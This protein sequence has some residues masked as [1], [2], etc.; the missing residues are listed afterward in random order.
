MRRGR[1]RGN[2]ENLRMREAFNCCEPMS[3]NSPEVNQI[4]KLLEDRQVEEWAADYDKTHQRVVCEIEKNRARFDDQIVSAPLGLDIEDVT[5]VTEKCLQLRDSYISMEPKIHLGM[6]QVNLPMIDQKHPTLKYIEGFVRDT[7]NQITKMLRNTCK[8]LLEEYKAQYESAR[9]EPSTIQEVVQFALD[10]TDSQEKI[11]PM[12][13]IKVDQVEIQ[14][15]YLTDYGFFS[16]TLTDNDFALG[17]LVIK[18]RANAQGEMEANLDQL[19]SRKAE[20]ERILQEKIDNYGE[21]LKEHFESCKDFINKEVPEVNTENLQER[22]CKSSELWETLQT[23]SRELEDLNRDESLLDLDATKFPLLRS[24]I[25]MFE[26]HHLLWLNSK[27]FYHRYDVWFYGALSE[28]SS[29]KVQDE[30]GTFKNNLSKVRNAL[31]E[32]PD[33]QQIAKDILQSINNLKDPLRL[34]DV[35][36]NRAMRPRHW[37]KMADE[38]GTEIDLASI[39]CLQDAI[40]YGLREHLKI[41]E[42]VSIVATNEFED[43]Q[44]LDAMK[45]EWDG[46]RFELNYYKDTG[47]KILSSVDKIQEALEEHCSKSQ[48]LLNSIFV[49]P[50]FDE[51]EEWTKRLLKIS[52]IFDV[53]I[54]VQQGWMYLQPIFG[55]PDIQQQMPQEGQQFS[56]VN[57]IF[58]KIMQYTVA[59]DLVLEA[60]EK[61]NLLD[62]LQECLSLLSTIKQR[63]NDYLEKKRAAFPRFFFLSNDELLEILAE[64]KDPLRVQPHLKKFFEGINRLQFDENKEIMGMESAEKEKVSFDAIIKPSE[65]KGLVEKWLC[66]TESEMFSSIKRE[67][68][69][70]IDDYEVTPRREWVQKWI[71]QAVLCGATVAWTREVEAAINEDQSGNCT[72]LKE[73]HDQC[74]NQITELVEL[75]RT[76]LPVGLRITLEALI[77]IDVHAKDVVKLLIDE[78]VCSVDSFVWLSQLRYYKGNNDIRVKMVQTDVPYGC[79]YLGNT[80]RL[81]ITPLTD[82]CYRTLMCAMDLHLGGAPEGPAG[83][84]KTETSKDLA[85]ALAKHCV[86]FNCSDQLDHVAMGKFF[87]GI[88]QCGSWA[89]FDEFNRIELEVLSVVAAQIQMIQEAKMKQLAIFDFEG[90]KIKLN[91]S[92][93]A[94]ITMNPG[95]AGRQELPDNLKRLFRPVAMMV[96][97]YALIGEL[98][99]Y[100]RGFKNARPLSVK[101]VQTYKLCS[102]QLSSQ[103]HYDYGMRAVKSVLTAAGNLKLADTSG[104]QSLEDESKLVLRAIIDVNRP[105]FL[106]EDVPLFE[107]ITADL[108]PGIELPPPDRG[109]LI[110][111]LQVELKFRNLQAT[112]WYME[113]LIQLYEM[114]LVR[115]GLM[116]V[117]P[118]F[119]GKTSAF[120]SLADALIRISKKPDKKMDESGVI[121]KIIS[122]KSI[123]S[124]QLYGFVDSVSQ[125]WHDGVLANT[126][127]DY[128]RS[129]EPERKWIILDG[130]VDAVWVENLNTVLDDNKKL[131]LSSGEVVQMSN[132]MNLIFETGDLDQA[133]PATVSRCGMVF[134]DPLQLGVTALIQSFVDGPLTNM[135]PN[136]VQQ[137]QMMHEVLLWIVPPTLAATKGIP[138]FVEMS[139]LYQFNAFERLFVGML[140]QKPDFTIPWMHGLMIFCLIWGAGSTL[141]AEGRKLFDAGFRAVLKDSSKK[142]EGFELADHQM[143]PNKGVLHDWVYTDGG[144]WVPWEEILESG[145]SAAGRALVMTPETTCMQF[146]LKLCLECQFPILFVGPTGTGKSAVTLDHLLSLPPEDC[147]SN[148]VNF[149]ART[150]AALTLDLIMDKLTKHPKRVFGPE[151]GKRCVVFVDDLNMPQKEFYGAQ[152]PIELLRQWLDHGYWFDADTTNMYIKDVRLVSAM[153]VPGNNDVTDRLLRQFIIIGVDKYADATVEKIFSNMVIGHF[154]S[155]VVSLGSSL[156]AASMEVFAQASSNF[157]PLPSTSHY[158][159]N[160]RD[161]SRLIQGC[162]MIPPKKLTNQEKL[163]RLWVHE[164]YRIFYDRLVSI[165]ERETFFGIVKDTVTKCFGKQL[166]SVMLDLLGPSDEPTD[167][168]ISKLYFGDF[169]IPDAYPRDYDEIPDE[170]LLKERLEAYLKEYNETAR[171]PMS[172]V[173]SPYAIGHICRVSRVLQQAN[174]HVLLMGMGGSGRR[175]V[176]RFAANLAGYDIYEIEMTKSFGVTEWRDHLRILLKRAGAECRPTVFLFSDTQ[177]AD[178]SFLEDI[179]LLLNTGDIPNL[180]NSEDKSIILDEVRKIAEKEGR[181]LGQGVLAQ[182]SFFIELVKKNL[183]VVLAMSPI[184]KE[185]RE[186]LRMFPSL[187]NC[188]TLDWLTNWPEDMLQDVANDRLQE[189]D[190]S[191]GL[192]DKEL[193]DKIKQR[194]ID[195]CMSFHTDALELSQIYFN[196][197]KRRVYITSP[198]FLELLNSFKALYATCRD[199]IEA[200]VAGYH[201]G[202]DKLASA[203]KQVAELQEVQKVLEVQLKTKAAEVSALIET[204]EEEKKKTNAIKET[205]Q[206]EEEEA[207]IS[208]AEIAILEA[209]CHT[210]LEKAQPALEE[211]AAALDT[212]KPADITVVKAMKNPPFAVKTVMEAVCIMLKI[213]AERKPGPDGKIVMEFWGPSQKLL[214]DIKFI[215]KLRNYDKDNITDDIMKTIRSKYLKNPNFQVEVVRKSSAACEGLCLWVNALSEYNEVYKVVGPL[216]KQFEEVQADANAKRKLLEEKQETV[217]LLEEKLQVLEQQYQEQADILAKLEADKELCAT[218]LQR[219]EALISGVGGERVRWAE[220]ELYHKGRL[221]TVVGDMLLSVGIIAY[222]GPFSVDYRKNIQKKWVKMCKE[223]NIPCSDSFSMLDSLGDPVEM[224]DWAIAGLPVDD[225]SQ[226]NAVIS[227]NAGRW[228][229]FI[230]P[231]GQ[232]NN[233]IKNAYKEKNLVVLKMSS[234]KYTDQLQKAITDGHPALIEDVGEELDPALNPL[235][236]KQTYILGGMLNIKV[237]NDVVRYSENF[238]LFLTTRLSNPHYLPETAIMVTLLNFAITPQGLEDQLLGLV[239]ATE[240]P[241]LEECRQLLIVESAQNRKELVETERK[242][243]DVLS[244]AEGDILEDET[245][246]N[247]LTNAKKLSETILAK[248]EK[249]KETEIMLEDAR[250]IYLTVARHASELFFCIS[251]LGSLEPMYQYSL[252]WYMNLYVHSIKTAVKPEDP[253]MWLDVIKETFTYNLYRNVCQSLFEKHKLIFS[254]NLCVAMMRLSGVIEES[255]LK[256]LLTTGV[257]ADIADNPDPSWITEKTWA[258]ICRATRMIEQLSGFEESVRSSVALW[259]DWFDSSNPQEETLPAPMD[260]ARRLGWLAVIKCLKPNKLVPAVQKLIAEEIGSQFVDPPTFNLSK[261]FEDSTCSTPLIF[262]LSAGS[263]PTSSLYQLS[264]EMDA[265]KLIFFSMG[266]G[267]GEKAEVAIKQAVKSRSWVIL[268]NCHLATSWMPRLEHI[269]NELLKPDVADKDFRLWLTSYPSSSFPVSILQSGIKMTNEA[270]KG[271]RSNMMRM[272]LNDPLSAEDYLSKRSVAQQKL[273]FGLCLFHAM[274]QERRSF[275]PLGWNIPYEFNDSDFDISVKQMD[276][277]LKGSITIPFDALHYLISECFYG[278]R[279]TDGNDRRLIAS[280]LTNFLSPAVVEEEGYNFSQSGVYSMPEST[281][282]EGCISNIQ[283]MPLTAKPELFGLHENAEITKEMQETNEFLHGALE[284][285]PNVGGMGVGS[286]SLQV[287]YDIAEDILER[288]PEGFNLKAVGEKYPFDYNNSMNTVLRQELIRFNR[289]TSRIRSS[290]SM[291]EKAM[292][293]QVVMTSDLEEIQSSLL[294]GRVPQFWLAKSYPS[295][296]PLSSYINDLLKRLQFF[297]DWIK[298]G[299]PKVYW[300]S[301]FYF[302]QSFLTGVMQNYARSFKVPIDA[303]GFEFDVLDTDTAN[304]APSVGAYCNGLFLE[305]ARFNRETGFLDESLPKILYDPLPIIWLKP[306]IKADFEPRPTY[307]CPV[308]KTSARRGILSTTGHSTNFVMEVQLPSNKPQSHWINRGVAALCQLDD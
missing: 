303:V 38:I 123:T 100:S 19:A 56:R 61:L 230:D 96:P 297:E 108:F 98:S 10:I 235:F 128:A 69:L 268:N 204:L 199:K 22:Y 55:S 279:V 243:L 28:L 130:P 16:D 97:D 139:E 176:A 281:L 276:K 249:A 198:S 154:S 264:I 122:T 124:D 210:E 298:F 31:A 194:C 42:D 87:K 244:K 241:D 196:N 92:C 149:S 11:L 111:A 214:G 251:S 291:M 193:S 25:E 86:V 115:H 49:A 131:C 234:P 305:G 51:M 133:S 307:G 35:L 293:G 212:I 289:L 85:K 269:C 150:S 271:L 112:D 259:R 70:S 83:T 90:S 283:A 12:L 20:E 146:F 101:I 171:S 306:G 89:C 148:V 137:V 206:K 32:F 88:S 58:V 225:F 266:K 14:M 127:R 166:K 47:V 231:Q 203:S 175:S 187:I 76:D 190:L 216:K 252:T 73:Y 247:T 258:E 113:K 15:E 181:K 3:E 117:G 27:N 24:G 118:P 164:A 229:L 104:S 79:E 45:E 308:Y 275:G 43:K 200:Q 74:E 81:V 23:L 80:P 284:T 233:W 286:A 68:L 197:C 209:K 82:R 21:R 126:F 36:C 208:A 169:M 105:K 300:I 227:H 261:V 273:L 143:I 180:Y 299:A 278:G 262:I 163:I 129:E 256:F 178:E 160:L 211:A 26:P 120:K 155:E 138:K 103:P 95:Y 288:M 282:Q 201:G 50:F 140:K 62:D 263:D 167:Q 257:T 168:H 228:P 136:Q 189:I 253:A 5:K 162:L 107:G 48:R 255:A 109:E 141:T 165:E 294:V 220:L 65:A 135:L 17:T 219:A 186:R 110:E 177:V 242:I 59:H 66:E 41:M 93:Q 134:M 44:K 285:Q 192:G 267:Q 218:K 13:S 40:N 223:M 157:R 57:R 29:N 287:L 179:N 296:K 151:H 84:G 304:E 116:L 226:D 207:K 173:M 121:F 217:R 106:A 39:Y 91:P 159:F 174:G 272:Y 184:S 265:K 4:Q 153:A 125:E 99:L 195:M 183:H 7:A 156:V 1:N 295:L 33:L 144:G 191:G 280:L 94:I 290:L 302:T 64:T 213:K 239:V 132:T 46:V 147:T 18:F 145:D 37:I 182:Y 52:K 240:R 158:L 245:A 67:V 236:L 237:G 232:A 8:K 221:T 215:E 72:K 270:P 205:V 53:W 60:T 54:P 71:G 6:F 9:R 119:G 114:I 277:F 152:P 188:C 63:V 246:I 2:P 224:Q 222:L 292:K 30:V 172:F 260:S 250:A 202:L 254:F 78:K 77:V 34:L 170:M 75:V 102:E 274:V 238:K 248:Q 161:I 301:G 185:F 142:P